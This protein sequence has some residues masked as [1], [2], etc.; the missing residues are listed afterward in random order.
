MKIGSM[1]AA[2]AMLLT[3]CAGSQ[4]VSNDSSPGPAGPAIISTPGNSDN[5]P[6]TLSGYMDTSAT[7]QVK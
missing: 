7:S 4:A 6:P 2:L 3:G 5:P 1:F